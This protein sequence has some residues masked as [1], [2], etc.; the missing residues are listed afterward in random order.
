MLK[1]T[2]PVPERGKV[3]NIFSMQPIC[4]VFVAR[5]LLD[6]SHITLQAVSVI[7]SFVKK[8]KNQPCPSSEELKAAYVVLPT[9]FHPPTNLA[10]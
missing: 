10:G 4:I 9:P 5:K 6:R 1:F 3:N 8:N 2:H 7:W